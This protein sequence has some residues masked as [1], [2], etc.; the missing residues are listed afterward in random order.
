MTKKVLL[1]I[2]GLHV[3]EA[4]EEDAEGN[5]P[6]EVITPASYYLK[7]GKHY[8]LYDEVT[9]GSAGITK[10]KIKITGNESLEI[11]KSGASSSHM[12]FEKNRMNATHYETPYGEIQVGVF[13]KS[14]R[15]EE[16]EDFIGVEVEYGLDVNSEPVADCHISLSVRPGN[17]RVL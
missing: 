11:I 17:A 13:T 12:I 15:V 2:S 6:I 3:M 16:S 4:M 9:E 5:E 8:I 10:N 7:N 1:T 14:M